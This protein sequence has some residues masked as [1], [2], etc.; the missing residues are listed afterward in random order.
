P[1]LTGRAQ[2]AAHPVRLSLD[3]GIEDAVGR[4]DRQRGI[5]APDEGLHGRARG[6]RPDAVD[7]AGVAA[8]TLQLL[9]QQSR[10]G[11]AILRSDR[12]LLRCWRRHRLGVT[13]GD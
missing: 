10:E 13:W 9:L 6:A 5:D 3:H 7:L 8:D 1:R 2:S 12:L 4:L 11:V